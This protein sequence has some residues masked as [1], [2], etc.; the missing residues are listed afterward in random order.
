MHQ[1]LH[2]LGDDCVLQFGGGII[3][4]PDGIQSGATVNRVVLECM[5]VVRNEGRD[6]VV[7]GL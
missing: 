6:Y 4:H 2:Y 3:G 1:L 7:E 5:V